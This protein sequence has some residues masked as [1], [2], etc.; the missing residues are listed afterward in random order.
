MQ[1][2]Q[3]GVTTSG[4]IPKR[5]LGKT[6]RQV[7]SFG[8]GGEGVL[9]TFGR[10]EEAA[11]VIER[12]L[13]LGVNYFDT[14]P[15]YAGSMDYLGTVIPPH[16]DKIFLACKTAER[17]RDGS[18][19]VLE[20][21]L[22]R[23]GVSS[24]DLWQLHDIRKFSE[25]D[26]IFAPD[27]AIQALLEAQR[28]GLVKYLGVTGHQDT[29]V[30]LEA[31]RRF[32]FDTVLM[33][34]NCADVHR[35]SFTQEVL[36]TALEKGM[37]VIAMKV[38]S[39]GLLVTPGSP[40]QPPALLRYALSQQGVST[41]II[42]CRTPQEVEENVRVASA[43]QPLPVEEQRELEGAYQSAQWTPYKPAR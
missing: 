25:V 21:A 39:G 2:L 37:G 41:A 1:S 6:G 15:A 33:P 8:L 36:P 3:N 30:L 27:G 26:R 38:Y 14:A 19:R 42:G 7:T 29:Q 32:D 24:F 34:V 13:E 9:R 12:A 18:L 17:T 35:R 22:R 23:L 16:R 4:A 11:R 31:L 10:Q 5:V 28:Q 43:F 40:A 20:D